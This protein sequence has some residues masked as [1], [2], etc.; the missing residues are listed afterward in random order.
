[1]KLGD[2]CLFYTRP[3][4]GGDLTTWAAHFDRDLGDGTSRLWVRLDDGSEMPMVGAHCDPGT[5]TAGCWSEV[6]A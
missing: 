5:P 4:F 3:P 6:P 1:M 2:H